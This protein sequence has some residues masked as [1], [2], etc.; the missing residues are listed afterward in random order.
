MGAGWP[1]LHSTP[2]S[3]LCHGNLPLL[4]CIFYVPIHMEILCGDMK[5]PL[6]N[7]GEIL[8]GDIKFPLCN[9][10]EILCGDIKFPLVT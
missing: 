10:G 7:I 3:S 8:C 2:G 6:C 9:I 1:G 5:F 4:M